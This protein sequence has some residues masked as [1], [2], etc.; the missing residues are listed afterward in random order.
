[1]QGRLLLSNAEERDMESSLPQYKATVA[2][3]W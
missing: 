3:V 2:L 1:M